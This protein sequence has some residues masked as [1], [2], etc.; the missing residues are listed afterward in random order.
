MQTVEELA[1]EMFI[2]PGVYR[3]H[4]FE[5]FVFT[6]KELKQLAIRFAQL[7]VQAALESA[8]QNMQLPEDDLEFTLDSYSLSKVK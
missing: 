5:D 6:G 2:D 1:I 7:H 4:Q 8:H 3:S